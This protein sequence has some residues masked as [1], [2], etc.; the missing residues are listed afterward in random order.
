[1]AGENIRDRF[2][3]IACHHSHPFKIL[4]CLRKHR[5]FSDKT[6]VERFLSSGKTVQF[7]LR[8]LARVLSRAIK[9][10]GSLN[11]CMRNNCL[12]SG[13]LCQPDAI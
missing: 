2:C 13:V 4:E 1:M 8:Q 6:H 12:N 9:G 10:N 3:R 11:F 7:Q 5:L